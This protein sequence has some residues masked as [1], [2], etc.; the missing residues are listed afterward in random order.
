MGRFFTRYVYLFALI[1]PSSVGHL[2]FAFCNRPPPPPPL[3]IFIFSSS[4]D[5]I[6]HWR[7]FSETYGPAPS[8]PPL[9][10][11]LTLEANLRSLAPKVWSPCLNYLPGPTR[12]QA[13]QCPIA[14][15]RPY[16]TR[17]LP[18]NPLFL[19]SHFFLSTVY[20]IPFPVC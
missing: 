5:D 11:A 10:L 13:L 8:L 17:S 18:T 6:S 19:N 1:F 12:F 4:G 7:S 16:P 14:F 9:P 3:S 15:T 2:C 20:R